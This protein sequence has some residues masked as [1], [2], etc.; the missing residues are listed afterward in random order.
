MHQAPVITLVN[1]TTEKNDERV[2]YQDQRPLADQ[3][4]GA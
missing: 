4:P 3:P 1:K 2:R